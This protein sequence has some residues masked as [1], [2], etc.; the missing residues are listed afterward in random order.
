MKRTILAAVI[1]VAGLAVSSY[2]Q[3]YINFQNYVANPY[4]A[5]VYGNGTKLGTQ[6]GSEASVE[7]GWANGSGVTSGFT[8]LPSS[9]TAI[10]AV[11][12]QPDNGSGPSITGWF[13]GPTVTLTGYI[14]GDAVS[15]EILATAPSYAG[16]LIWTEPASN[17]ATGTA[18]V[19]N[20]SAMPGDIV[21]LNVPEPTTLALGILGGL[22]LLAFRRKQA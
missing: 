15:F 19:N 12:S 13:I 21:L 7:L 8:M 20:F 16:S 1:G 14:P 2:G 22:S 9:T 18:H 11:D 4:Y 17:I 3:G 10:S 6:V 5:V